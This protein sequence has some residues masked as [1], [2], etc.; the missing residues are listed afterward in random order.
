M[1]AN[2]G[3][4]TPKNWISND[5]VVVIPFIPTDQISAK[6]GVE[7]DIVEPYLLRVQGNAVD[8]YVEKKS[9]NYVI[10]GSFFKI[11]SLQNFIL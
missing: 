10:P 1:T 5:K 6:F 2:Y 11:L 9:L 4:E 8:K 3:L 7:P